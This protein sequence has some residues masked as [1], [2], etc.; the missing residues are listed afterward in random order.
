MTPSGL[1]PQLLH[2][3]AKAVSI[4]VQRVVPM[5]LVEH[6][7]GMGDFA[8]FWTILSA[9]FSDYRLPMRWRWTEVAVR[10]ARQCGCHRQANPNLNLCA[11]KND[12]LLV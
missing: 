2:R 9:L 5:T 12:T 10:V 7:F 3:G 11:G 4:A 6:S 1:A 8:C